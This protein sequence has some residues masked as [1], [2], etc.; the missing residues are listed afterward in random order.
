[1][2]GQDADSQEASRQA[3]RQRIALE[4]RKIELQTR[5]IDLQLRELELRGA[6]TKLATSPT[7]QPG[8]SVGIPPVA[9]G[10]T[11]SSVP[12]I[13][14]QKPNSHFLEARFG[15]IANATVNPPSSTGSLANPIGAQTDCVA[16]ALDPPSVSRMKRAICQ[17]GRDISNQLAGNTLDTDNSGAQVMTVLAAK[18][19]TDND[20]KSFFLDA[21]KKR[22]DKQV[23]S[24]PDSPGT[25]SLVVKGGTPALI[26]WAVEQGA[27]TSSVS[28]NTVSV[29][30]NPHN[31]AKAIFLN[32]GLLQIRDI[33]PQDDSF[34]KF[35]RNLSV[36]LSFD[37][38]RGV[39]TPTFTAKSN[40][41]SAFSFRY[42]FINR[43]NPLSQANKKLREDFF[44][45]QTENLDNI[46]QAILAV[47]GRGSGRFNNSI[48][49]E[50][51]D[52]T[53]VELAKIPTNLAPAD[54]RTRVTSVI[55][56][57]L[58]KL[59]IDRLSEIDDVKNAVRRYAVGSIE[60]K[61]KRD[62]LLEEVNDGQIATFEYTNNREPVAPDTS[63]FRFIWEKGIFR[64]TDFTFNSSL[65]MYNKKPIAPG[66]KRIRDFQFALQTDT[67]LGDRFGTGDLLLSFAGRYERLN[68]DTI[69]AL[70]VVTPGTKG[71]LALGQIKLTIPIADWGIKIPLSMTFANRT[72][73]IK[74][75]N[76]RA[77]FGFTFD[78]DPIFARLKP[79]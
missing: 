12:V 36:G 72:E 6:G 21:E 37:I 56:S 24:G 67:K 61:N 13:E 2:A 63:N 10:E 34:D 11:A 71:D 35:L 20:V 77:N 17:I 52:E 28:G 54:R 15:A 5:D 55:E 49:N 53:N 41:L 69:D 74:E 47:V 7:D 45:S 58:E 48:L 32:Q 30:F 43:R 66:V 8:S 64:K 76:V 59:P 27:A 31:F 33:K 51:L 40:Q 3:E 46:A 9:R 23:G 22:T 50:W 26:G 75:S 42:E 60:F 44:E 16:S 79:F 70:G 19:S 25:T 73:L 29:R 39:E 18:L 62:D 68:G 57:R 4:R 1:M 78:L 38:S 65:T 14:S